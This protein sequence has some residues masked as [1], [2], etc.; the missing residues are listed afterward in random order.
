MGQRAECTGIETDE[1]S[2][3]VANLGWR[4]LRQK[5][6]GMTNDEQG[7]TSDEGKK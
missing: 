5:K 2:L 3:R 1:K 4:R 7:M 6:I